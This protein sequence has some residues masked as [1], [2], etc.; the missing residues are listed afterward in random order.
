MSQW[1]TVTLAGQGYTPIRILRYYYPD[2][3]EIVETNAITNMISSYPGTPL[4][5][6]STGLDVQTIQ[7]YLNRI[8]GNL[9]GQHPGGS[10]EIPEYFRTRG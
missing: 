3:V 5:V 10:H 4:R 8:G 9:W 6:G 7:T 1:G 2:D